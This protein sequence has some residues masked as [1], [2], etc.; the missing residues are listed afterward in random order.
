MTATATDSG[1]RARVA[2][3]LAGLVAVLGFSFASVATSA[4][5]FA[6]HC[7]DTTTDP[8]PDGILGNADDVTTTTERDCTT[9]EQTDHI[10]ASTGVGV[11]NAQTVIKDNMPLVFGVAVAFVAW[12]VGRRVLGKI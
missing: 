1:T 10:D 6:D 5:A 7:S 4:P 12:T 3:L 2:L 11:D 9:A 8:G